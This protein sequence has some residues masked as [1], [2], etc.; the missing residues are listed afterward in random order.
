MDK[1]QVGR[2]GL[3]IDTLGLGGAPLGGNFVDLDTNLSAA[4]G[5]ARFTQAFIPCARRAW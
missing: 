2:A 1:R 5:I 3:Y 4:G